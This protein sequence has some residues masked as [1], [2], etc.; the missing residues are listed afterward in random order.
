MVHLELSVVFCFCRPVLL[1]PP[2]TK[3]M[4]FYSILLCRKLARVPG[5]VKKIILT[6]LGGPK[7]NI[8]PKFFHTI[9]SLFTSHNYIRIPDFF[10][11]LMFLYFLGNYEFALT[12]SIPLVVVCKFRFVMHKIFFALFFRKSKIKI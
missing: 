4:L 6:K 8:S 2:I 1:T 10:T 9:F 7:Q 12:L 11:L 3:Y 5:V